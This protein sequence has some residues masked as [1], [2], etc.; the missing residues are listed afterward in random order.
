MIELD[1]IGL[2]KNEDQG[3]LNWVTDGTKLVNGFPSKMESS[4]S[5]DGFD[6]RCFWRFRKG[7]TSNGFP[8]YRVAFHLPCQ[9]WGRLSPRTG[10]NEGDPW[11][12]PTKSL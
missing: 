2:S 11:G 8:Y 4:I 9:I 7:R 5:E 12:S 1:L 6:Q 10:H 3:L